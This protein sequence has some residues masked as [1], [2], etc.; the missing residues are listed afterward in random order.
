MPLSELP[1]PVEEPSGDEPPTIRVAPPGPLSRGAAA[2]LERVECPAFVHRRKL[3]AGD[4]E[5]LALPIVLST[6]RG[7]N[8]HDVDGNRYVDLAAGFGAVLLGHGAASVRGAV[9][10]QIER[11]AQGLGDLY[12]TD[13]KLALLERLAPLHPGESPRVLLGQSGSDAITAA[14]KTAVLATGRPGVVAFEGAYHGLGYAP[15]PACGLRASYREPFAAQLN[16]H[17][18]FSPYPRAAGDLDATIA[19]VEAHLRCGDVGAILVEPI[20]GRGGVVVPPSGFLSAL[21]EAARR[22]GAL[23]VADEI[24]TGLGRSGALVRSLEAGIVPDVICLGKGLG[25]GLP[26]A[27]CIAPEPVMRAW[28]RGGEVVHTST[29]AGAPL[30]C[31]AAIATLDSLKFRHLVAR[32]RELGA[33]LVGALR[34]ATEGVPGV[35][36]VRGEGLM[37][38]VELATPELG[39]AAARRL[40]ERGWVVTTGG[41][42]GDVLTLT[43][44]LTIAEHLLL[45]FPEALVGVLRS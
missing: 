4:D 33:K 36:D 29:H 27:A 14:L 17:V 32:S 45:Q 39:Q 19:S 38:G 42:R 41:A 2:R 43:P 6:G 23:L 37:V 22:A 8:L 35:V 18:R 7:S 10:G 12:A 44:P 9:E 21:A 31:A 3:R 1:P 28:A 13:T 24:W 20:L 30:A 5:A 16:P 25:G 11:L 40:L 34:A 26:I 15:L